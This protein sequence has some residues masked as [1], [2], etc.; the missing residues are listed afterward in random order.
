MRLI[1]SSRE[2]VV[3]KIAEVEPFGR[4]WTAICLRRRPFL[5]PETPCVS[6]STVTAHM[7]CLR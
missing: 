4:M 2:V 1:S 7:H 5:A 3:R 6:P